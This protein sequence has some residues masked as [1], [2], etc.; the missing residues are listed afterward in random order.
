MSSAIKCR[1]RGIKKE[2]EM[3]LKKT[4]TCG[5]NLQNIGVNSCMVGQSDNQFLWPT[6]HTVAPCQTK[7]HNVDYNS[8]LFG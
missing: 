6:K 1:W 7:G 2:Q 3:L 5:T 4:S 8:E